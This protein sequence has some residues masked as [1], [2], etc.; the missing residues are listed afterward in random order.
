MRQDVFFQPDSSW[1]VPEVLPQFAP[2]ETIAVDLETYDPNLLINGPGWATGN[3]HIVGVGVA[4]KSWSGYLPIRH[5]GG[6]NL[7][8]AVVMRWLKNVLSTQRKVIFHN[9]L[10][11][12]GWLKREGIDIQGTIL[13]T[14]I[15]APLLDE[16]RFSYSLD[17]LGKDWCN[18]T[19]D[20]TLL[21]D[22]ALTFGVNPK[23]E[24][25]KICWSLWRTRCSI[26]L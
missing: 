17:N 23:S 9:S 3:G 18:E 16:N 15:A 6:G 5:S 8:Q 1:T 2:N 13:D 22:A 24:M 19:K 20:E 26:N 7:D 25:Y 4:S 10:Y 14:I 12:V 21:Q 11:D